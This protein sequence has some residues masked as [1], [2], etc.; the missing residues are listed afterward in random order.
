MQIRKESETE[1]EKITVFKNK[2]LELLSATK[3][4]NNNSLILSRRR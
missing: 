1:V 3:T 4:I 2:P